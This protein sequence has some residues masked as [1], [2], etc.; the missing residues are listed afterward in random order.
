MIPFSGTMYN[1]VFVIIPMH[2]LGCVL[3]I[4]NTLFD[5][6]SYHTFPTSLVSPP[7]ACSRHHLIRVELHAIHFNTDKY[8]RRL[9]SSSSLCLSFSAHRSA[10]IVTKRTVS[11]N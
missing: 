2:A 4:I 10:N 1:Y 7:L 8:I 3:F 5:V 11:L 6:G 9:H